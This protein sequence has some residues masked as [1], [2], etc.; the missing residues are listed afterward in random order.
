MVA[1]QI[2]KKIENG[3]LAPGGQLP[4]QREL[5]ELLG[6][7]RSSVR[8]ATNA[9]VAMGYLEVLQ[10]KGT[11]VKKVPPS[12]GSAG[13]HL[14]AVIEAGSITDLMEAREFL[15]CTSAELAARRAGSTGI[16]QMESALATIRASG[17][18][19]DNFLAA[20]LDFHLALAEAT[21]NAVIAE[22]T[23]LVIDQV[24]RHH[25]SFANTLLSAAARERTFRSA[26]RIVDRVRAGDGPAASDCM[27]EHL[28]AVGTELRQ[29]GFT[30]DKPIGRPS[31]EASP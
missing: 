1:A 24:H 13:A 15:E 8:E 7:G 17:G 31:G 19:I 20:D 21:D 29:R 23:K 10:G 14:Q 22:M 11:F 4:A 18:D 6:V 9:L 30:A 5:A 28:H 25:A 2:L 27:R 12:N 26:R 3:E 16:E